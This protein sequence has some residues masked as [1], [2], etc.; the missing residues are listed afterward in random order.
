M[1][2]FVAARALWNASYFVTRV[3]DSGDFRS[4]LFS[5]FIL[6]AA[7]AMGTPLRKPPDAEQKA[8]IRAHLD[9]S[10]RAFEKAM[11]EVMTVED[12]LD[13]VLETLRSLLTAERAMVDDDIRPITAGSPA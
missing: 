9:G 8:K 12:G 10:W 1:N 6:E 3:R 5:Q 2:T 11:G 7:E 4:D 13:E